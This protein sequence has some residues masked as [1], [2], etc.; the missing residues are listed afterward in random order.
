MAQRR[1]LEAGAT[2]WHSEASAAKWHNDVGWKPALR[3]G[4][5][6]PALRNRATRPAGS[7]RYEMAL[8]RDMEGF[9]WRPGLARSRFFL[10]PNR[11]L[12]F[13]PTKARV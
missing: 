3:N 2:K 13:C 1:R 6:K 7:R 4:I 9:D 12:L 11:N 5:A 8:S 10:F